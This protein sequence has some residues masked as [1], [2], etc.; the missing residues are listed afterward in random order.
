[1]SQAPP[2]AAPDF[3]PRQP[4]LKVPAGSCDC[5]AHILGPAARFPYSDERVYTPPDC[6]LADYRAMLTALGLARAVLV[7]PSVYSSD[8]RVLLN[9]LDAMQGAWR[10]VAVVEPD[11]SASALQEMHAAGVRGVRVN[12]VDVQSNKGVLP[13]NQL[14]GLAERIA[15]LGWHMEFLLHVHEF[16]RLDQQL[17]GFPVDVVFGHLGYLPTQ[18]GIG[19]AGFQ[20]LLLLLQAGRAWIKLTG[21]YRLSGSKL[22]YADVVP[23]AHALL[24]A[25]PRQ[26]VWGS[27]WPHVMVKGA[28]PNDGDLMDI[29]STWIPDPSIRH[30]VLVSNP[31]RL[32]GFQSG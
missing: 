2:C 21:P 4:Q 10:G 27:D 18:L 3:A 15:P 19:D 9:A 31:E 22:P 11:V 25:A 30:Q 26:I 12:V 29:L 7:Q 16:P 17:A 8:N 5:H 6:L 23:F 14:R 32:Y 1:M 13:L 28:M 20:A 24:D